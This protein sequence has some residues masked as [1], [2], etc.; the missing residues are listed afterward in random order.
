MRGLH[1]L[2]PGERACI[3]RIT[4]TGALARRMLD[5]GLVP[6]VEVEVIRQAPWGGPIQV[7]VKGYYLAMRKQECARILVNSVPSERDCRTTVTPKAGC[8]LA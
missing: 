1:E 8:C 6:G 3:T 5:M 7:R 2:R 4:T